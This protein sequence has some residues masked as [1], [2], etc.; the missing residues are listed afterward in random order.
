MLAS[1]SSKLL[2]LLSVLL[3][4]IRRSTFREFLFSWPLSLFVPEEDEKEVHENVL[5][6]IVFEEGGDCRDT[7]RFSY[8]YSVNNMKSTI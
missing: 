4:D 7:A 6:N 2:G 5:E 8:I 1:F 3:L